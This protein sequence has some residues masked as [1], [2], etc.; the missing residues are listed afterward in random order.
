MGEPVRATEDAHKFMTTLA[1]RGALSDALHVGEMLD[2]LWDEGVEVDNEARAITWLR[3]SSYAFGSGDTD[4]SNRISSRVAQWAKQIGHELLYADALFQLGLSLSVQ[5]QTSNAVTAMERSLRGMKTSW[6]D[7][8]PNHRRLWQ[9]KWVIFWLVSKDMG[10]FDQSLSA[11]L[12]NRK[13][14]MGNHEMIRL[15]IKSLVQGRLGHLDT[16]IRTD[17]DHWLDGVTLNTP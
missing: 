14:L 17:L 2:E 8:H 1:T 7:K 3:M 5:G 4:K 12:A 6:L 9:L 16:E 10:K 11:F 15:L 13:V